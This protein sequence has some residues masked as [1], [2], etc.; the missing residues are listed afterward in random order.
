MAGGAVFCLRDS[1]G[2]RNGGG[3]F[4]CGAAFLDFICRLFSM[5]R[6]QIRAR[7]FQGD[8]VLVSADGGSGGEAGNAAVPRQILDKMMRLKNIISGYFGVA[9][10]GGNYIPTFPFGIWQNE[11]V[12]VTPLSL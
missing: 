5:V 6:E 11:G 2:G 4:G 3:S 7:S 10:I 1:V 12:G 9:D 8:H